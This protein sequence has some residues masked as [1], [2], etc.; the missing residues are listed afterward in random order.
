[1]HLDPYRNM[2]RP[3]YK[4]IDRYTQANYHHIPYESQ[5]VP[6]Q[7]LTV[8]EILNRYSSGLLPAGILMSSAFEDDDE[9]DLDVDFV[10]P[11]MRQ[12][13]DLTDIFELNREEESY[14]RAYRRAK[15]QSEKPTDAPTD[16][17][18]VRSEPADV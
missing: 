4:V 5:T 3:D 11:E 18:E 1:M 10:S 7:S 9:S 8:K 12:N 6:D 16:T 2:E 17:T 15:E 14:K 13:K